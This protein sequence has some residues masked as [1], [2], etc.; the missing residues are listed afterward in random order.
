MIRYREILRLH[1]QG[2][3]KTAIARSCECS[4]NTVARVVQRAEEIG[5]VWPL[6]LEL[7]DAKLQKLLLPQSD[8]LDITVRRSRDSV[9][10]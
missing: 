5:I 6:D 2:I 3:S 8:L 1:S 9:L 10:K 7:S 4:R